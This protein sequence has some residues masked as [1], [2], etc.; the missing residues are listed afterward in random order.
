MIKIKYAELTVIGGAPWGEI[1]GSMN[2]RY[3]EKIDPTRPAFYH[4]EKWP[5]EGVW[6]PISRSTTGIRI[7]TSEAAEILKKSALSGF[8]AIPLPELRPFRVIPPGFNLPGQ[9]WILTP[10]G[11]VRMIESEL[12]SGYTDR[13]GHKSQFIRRFVPALEQPNARDLSL[14]EN[15]N[16]HTLVCS[17]R[18][19]EVFRELAWK[20]VRFHPLDLMDPIGHEI[21]PTAKKWPPQWYP[22]G[23]EP[24]PNNLESVSAE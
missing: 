23:V 4:V 2:I 1:C 6:P 8:K 18:A 3:P 5:R 19:V 17:M 13:D 14:V 11:R 12:Y 15:T 16:S 7:L 10:T 21:D 20:D 9:L 24:H 22:D